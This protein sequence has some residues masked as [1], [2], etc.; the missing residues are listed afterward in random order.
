MAKHPATKPASSLA[1]DRR[2]TSPHLTRH[3]PLAAAT[4]LAALLTMMLG[5]ARPGH[6]AAQLDAKGETVVVTSTGRVV[7]GVADHAIIV[8]AVEG[9]ATGSRPPTILPI[10]PTYIGVLLGTVEWDTPNSKAKPS[11]LDTDLPPA[12]ISAARRVEHPEPNE[13]SDIEKIGVAI[14]ELIRPQLAKMH[15]KL[16]LAPDQPIFELILADY[17]FDYGPEIWR[18]DYRAQQEDLGND[19]WLTRPLRPAYYQLYPPE[20]G[21]PRTLME[22]EYPKSQQSGLLDRMQRHDPALD[23][24]GA[25]SAEM[26]SAVTAIL[27]GNTPKT[28]SMAL[29]DFLHSAIPAAYGSKSRLSMALLDDRRGFQWVI[30]P[31]EGLPA[32]D[33]A[34]PVEPGAPTLRRYEPPQ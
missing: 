29:A 4:L 5:S 34:K 26:A 28:T 6:S 12:A 18:L 30:P 27:G 24:I 22:V 11:R 2:F 25:A 8:A 15:D 21:H 20:K 14:L 13:P 19:Y 32:P 10:G 3:P 23:P 7:L 33:P 31:A 1:P 9:G 17:A 16:N